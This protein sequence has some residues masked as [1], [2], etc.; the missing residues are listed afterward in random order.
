MKLRKGQLAVAVLFGA[1]AALYWLHMIG[2]SM[3]IDTR[4]SCFAG[5]C[6]VICM[7]LGMLPAA[8]PQPAETAF[9]G[10]DRMYGLHK[11]LGIAALV[12]FVAH[13][14]TVPG[15]PDGEDVESGAVPWAEGRAVAAPD[16]RAVGEAE[17]EL[18][19]DLFGLIAMIGFVSLIIVTL[20]RKVPITAGSPATGSWGCCSPSS[21]SM[22]F[23][24]STTVPR[25]RRSRRRESRS[26]RCCS[27]G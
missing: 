3:P 21:A 14:A 7:T 20:N 18:P 9:G 19:I 8:R 4:L 26:P 11:H 27:P 17:D 6:S 23:S 16:A 10:L 1:Y 2:E 13:F 12:L 22:S 15:G 25:S 24:R 5:V